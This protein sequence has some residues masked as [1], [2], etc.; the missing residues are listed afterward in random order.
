MS[1]NFVIPEMV[2]GG[3]SNISPAFQFYRQGFVFGSAP[4]WQDIV[5]RGVGS[6]TL[7]NAKSDGL[8][9]VKLFGKCELKYDELPVGYTK[10]AYLQSN[11]KQIINTN[12]TLLETDEVEIDYNLYD[13][14]GGGDKFIMG[15][16]SV[17]SVGGGVWVET[18]GTNNKWYV[19]FGSSSSSNADF[20]QSQQ[21]GTFIVKK[22]AFIVNGTQILSPSY[23]SIPNDVVTLF[24]RTTSFLSIIKPREDS[25]GKFLLQRDVAFV[26][27][28]L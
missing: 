27:K 15:M 13:L 18:F 17:P 6:L 1:F 3:K 5:L 24:A 7:T 14:T 22:N 20:Q 4:T 25:I 9:Y 21:S 23:T 8:N 11:R 16:R 12:Y 28:F 2:I 19:R 26:F 10:V